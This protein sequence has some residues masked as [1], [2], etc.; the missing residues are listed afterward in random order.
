MKASQSSGEILE[1]ASPLQGNRTRHRMLH[2]TT[3]AFRFQVRRL[4][5]E[6]PSRGTVGIVDQHEMRMVLQALGLQLHGAAVLL[7]ELGEDKFQQV[8]PKGSQRKR[9][10]AATTSMRHWLRVMG[11]TVVRDQSHFVP[12]RMV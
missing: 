10:Q 3:G 11:V 4:Q 7:D 9:F 8:G 6:I 1:S 2:L 5:L 12:A